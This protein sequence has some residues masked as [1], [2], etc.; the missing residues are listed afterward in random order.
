MSYTLWIGNKAYSSWSLRGWL[1]LE[2][3]DIPFEENLVRM[4]SSE[5]EAARTEHFP[6]RT[7]PTLV[8]EDG[9]RRQMI[10]DSL[11]IVEFL[12]ERHPKAGH[13]PEDAA[14]R[15]AARCLAADMHSGYQAL[16]S[17]MPMNLKRDYPG[18]GVTP[19]VLQDVERLAALWAWARESFPSEGPYLFGSRL[20]VADVFFCP[21]ANRLATYAVEL[22]EPASVYCA[23][24]RAHPAMEK[25]RAAAVQEPWVEPRYQYED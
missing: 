20:T 13:W 21:V 18:R 22:P 3:F 23:A 1:L 8:F 25:W 6:S 5:F 24:L 16:R 15:A 2:A 7:V 19:G 17:N 14:A 10:W 9:D 11:A 12:A 4:Y